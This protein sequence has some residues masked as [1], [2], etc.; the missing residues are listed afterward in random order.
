MFKGFE[1]ERIA[2]GFAGARDGAVDE[3]PSE[4]RQ[5]GQVV[6]LVEKSCWI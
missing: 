1:V 2:R 6:V 4:C 3:H 5:R